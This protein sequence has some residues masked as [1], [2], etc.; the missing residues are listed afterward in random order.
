MA[1]PQKILVTGG[2]GFIGSHVVDHYLEAGHAVAV[3]DN[4]ATGN[5]EN[6]NPAAAFYE[7][8]IRSDEL[9]EVFARERP[10]V[11]NHHAAQASVPL[12]V[13]RPG[14]DAE[15][16]LLGSLNLLEQARQHGVQRVIYASTGG[17]VYGEPQ[18]LPCDEEHPIRPLSP[19]G[20]SK[21]AVEHYLQLYEQLYG[22]GYTILRY[23]NVYG[24]R[25]DPHGE[26]GV[27]AI[28]TSQMLAGEPA[29]VHG[30]G[31]QER[32]LVYAGDCARANV[33]A[34][35]QDRDGIFNIGSGAGTTINDL[36]ERLAKLTGYARPRQHGPARLGDVYR[37]FLSCDLAAREL[38]W[39]PAFD[40]D[41]GLQATVTYFQQR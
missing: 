23:A 11:V 6:V 4:L 30:D 38:G 31:L 27:V 10:D 22:L 36:F 33:A 2:A 35:E 34:L 7:V 9:A 5:R 20:A 28:F 41:Q 21:H 16:N 18:Y 12:S 26:A 25:Q 37:S 8:D 15:V 13:S 24:P 1:T 17:A 32:D 40:L 29:I 39:Q 19:Y 14:Y 3:V